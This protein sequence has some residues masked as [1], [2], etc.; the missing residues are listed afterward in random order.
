MR[1]LHPSSKTRGVSHMALPFTLKSILRPKK[2]YGNSNI[3]SYK[4][5]IFQKSSKRNQNPSRYYNSVINLKFQ[6]QVKISSFKI[7]H[8]KIDLLSPRGQNPLSYYTL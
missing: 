4:N 1:I 6:H 2:D 5:I 8:I 3:S 7:P